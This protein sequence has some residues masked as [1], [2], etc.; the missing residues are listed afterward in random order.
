MSRRKKGKKAGKFKKP[1]S[2]IQCHKKK[3]KE[4]IGNLVSS[5]GGRQ[6]E[7]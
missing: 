3:Y 1:S 4:T 5:R 7:R 6:G 2:G